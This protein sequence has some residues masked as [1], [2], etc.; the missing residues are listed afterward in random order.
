[1]A[2]PAAA[3]AEPAP[4]RSGGWVAWAAPLV[5]VA[6]GLAAYANALGGPFV[7]DDVQQVR[8]NPLVRDLGAF[9]RHGYGS[10]PARFV[11][12]LTFALDHRLGGGSPTVFH[13]FNVAVHLA[14]AL[15]VYAL[16]A[17]VFRTPRV[18][19]SAVAPAW[20]SI[21]LLAATLF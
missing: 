10:M 11:A 19:R 5:V 15:L 9:L 3:L 6:V 16:V 2:L 12:Y 1:M 7:F 18:S 13:A 14:T 21:A 20:R 17:L 8:D 4:E